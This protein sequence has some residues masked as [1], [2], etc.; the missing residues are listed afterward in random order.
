MSV[1]L[2][3]VLLHEYKLRALLFYVST[4]R[5]FTVYVIMY[6]MSGLAP[7]FPDNGLT[8]CW[9]YESDAILFELLLKAHLVGLVPVCPCL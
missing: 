7:R 9:D 6:Q 3:T 8:W 4:C 2:F 5:D 1:F